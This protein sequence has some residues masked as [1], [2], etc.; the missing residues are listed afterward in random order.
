MEEASAVSAAPEKPA[1][2]L[3]A[4][5]RPSAA[6]TNAEAEEEEDSTMEAEG[7]GAAINN[8]NNNNSIR[9]STEDP[10]NRGRVFLIFIVLEEKEGSENILFVFSHDFFLYTFDDFITNLRIPH[11]RNASR[12]MI[13]FEFSQKR[14]YKWNLK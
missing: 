9:I 14:R 11:F 3:V 10:M 5:E 2:G 6:A 1:Y 7:D 4:A 8:N 13:E 12:Y